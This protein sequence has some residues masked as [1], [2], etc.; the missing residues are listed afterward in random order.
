VIVLKHLS[1]TQQT[2]LIG[3]VLLISQGPTKWG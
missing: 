1:T 2:H 3:S